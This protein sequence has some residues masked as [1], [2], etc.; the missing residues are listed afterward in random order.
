V[1][2]D[3]GPAVAHVLSAEPG[4]ADDVDTAALKAKMNIDVTTIYELIKVSN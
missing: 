3:A 4:I 1:V 2:P